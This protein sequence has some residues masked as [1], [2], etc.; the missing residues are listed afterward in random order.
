MH[1]LGRRVQSFGLRIQDVGLR[2]EGIEL[3]A[4]SELGVWDAGFLPS[5][6]RTRAR[7]NDDPSELELLF[8]TLD[9]KW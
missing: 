9:P 5:F 1:G 6:Q 4:G 8:K 7:I 2:V 3:R